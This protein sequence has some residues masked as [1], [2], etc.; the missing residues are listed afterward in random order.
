MFGFAAAAAQPARGHAAAT[1]SSMTR[2][3]DVV[4]GPRR[5]RAHRSRRQ[6]RSLHLD[7][8]RFDLGGAACPGPHGL[9]R[10]GA[11]L[12]RRIRSASPSARTRPMPSAGL[13][14]DDAADEVADILQ[15]LTLRE[16]RGFSHALR[17]DASSASSTRSMPLSK[18]PH[19]QAGFR[20]LRA[21]DVPSVLVELGYLSS[22][23]GHRPPHCPTTWRDRSTAAMATAIDRFSPPASRTRG[24]TCRQFHHRCRV[25]RAW[26]G[27]DSSR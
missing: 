8:R 24:R 12:R 19:R 3:Q 26:R 27:R 15:E 21:P 18:K 2:D 20:V 17:A 22:Q 23:Q 10:L 25:E 11:G 16:T 4:R 5:A 13:D 9:Y 14:R 6:G 1:G 7:P